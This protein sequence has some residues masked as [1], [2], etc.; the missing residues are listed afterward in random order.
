MTGAPPM[1]GGA[2]TDIA[3][4]AVDL[5]AAAPGVIEAEPQEDPLQCVPIGYRP[6]LDSSDE[7]E[8]VPAEGESGGFDGGGRAAELAEEEADE[9]SHILRDRKLCQWEDVKQGGE[10]DNLLVELGSEALSPEEVEGA[11]AA[12][13]VVKECLDTV[14]DKKH[15]AKAERSRARH[16]KVAA[17]SVP[18]ELEEK[19]KL[20]EVA[21][22]GGEVGTDA[23]RG[24]P[25]WGR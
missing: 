13:A 6:S 10:V 16:S 18:K 24:V 15:L 1:V 12:G 4:E 22:D 11:A 5:T 14:E 20:F 25:R 19:R 3:L 2:I 9:V 8:D 21:G 23:E 7:L 17:S